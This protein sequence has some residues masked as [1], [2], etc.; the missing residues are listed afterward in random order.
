VHAAARRVSLE[1]SSSFFKLV[2]RPLRRLYLTKQP[3]ARGEQMHIQMLLKFIFIPFGYNIFSHEDSRRLERI[4]TNVYFLLSPAAHSSHSAVQRHAT[5][6]I[7]KWNS[8]DYICIFLQFLL[9]RK[10]IQ[11]REGRAMSCGRLKTERARRGL[12]RG[13]QTSE[14]EC[15]ELECFKEKLEAHN[16]LE[17]HP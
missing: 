11:S 7:I 17:L 6:E 14:W 5:R 3:P 12:S 8:R 15:E 1:K 16:M 4:L 9:S 2:A 13:E 10:N